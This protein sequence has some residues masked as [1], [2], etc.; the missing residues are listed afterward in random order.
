MKRIAFI[1]LAISAFCSS[2]QAA[3]NYKTARA[4]AKTLARAETKFAK[5]VAKLSAADREKLKVA[6]EKSGTDSDSDGVSD[7]YERARGSDLC[8]IDSDGDGVDDGED[9]YEDSPDGDGDGNPDGAEVGA[10]GTITSFVD[11]TLIVGGKTFTVTPQTVFRGRNFTKESLVAGQCI[12]V[13]GHGL[14]G[15]NTADKIKKDDDC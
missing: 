10:K 15:A 6:L 14:N 13:E 5:L 7:L 1:L 12:E 9:Q 4:E 8:S 11:P 2:A 3:P